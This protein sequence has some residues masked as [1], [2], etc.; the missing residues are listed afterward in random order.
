MVVVFLVIGV[1]Q[2]VFF[3]VSKLYFVNVDP[4]MK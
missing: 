1:L 3:L 2:L 4:S